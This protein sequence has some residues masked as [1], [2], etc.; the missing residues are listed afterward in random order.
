MRLHLPFAFKHVVLASVTFANLVKETPVPHKREVR[1]LQC[2]LLEFV[3]NFKDG[4]FRHA[5]LAHLNN[6]AVH[7]ALVLTVPPFI[8]VPHVSVYLLGFRA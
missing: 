2:A 7:Q 4:L 8:E 5:Q 6:T 3:A 1:T